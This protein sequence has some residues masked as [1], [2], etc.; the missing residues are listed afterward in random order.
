MTCIFPSLN[1]LECIDGIRCTGK[2]P[3][4]CVECLAREEITNRFECGIPAW[5]FTCV[6]AARSSVFL[7]LLKLGRTSER[8]DLGKCNNIPDM[9]H[10]WQSIC[11]ALHGGIHHFSQE[12]VKR[13]FTCEGPLHLRWCPAQLSAFRY[14]LLKTKT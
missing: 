8:L 12:Y 6:T 7:S 2:F 10:T 13:S 3:K 9:L 1:Q 4:S 14:L 5:K 11:R